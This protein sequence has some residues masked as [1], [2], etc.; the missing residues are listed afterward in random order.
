LSNKFAIKAIP[1]LIVQAYYEMLDDKGFKMAA[2]LSYYAVFSM[3]P[4]LIIIIAIAG[5]IFGDDAAKGQ[6]FNEMKS[7]L[8]PEGALMIETIVKGAA[9]TSTGIF[10]TAFSVV[11]LVLGSVGVFIE[12]QESLNIIWGVEPRPGRGIWG[13]LKLRLI[14]FSMV[15]ATAFLLMVSLV[16]NSAVTMLNTYMSEKFPV[17]IPMA[18]IL[19]NLGSL[20]VTILLFALIYKVLPDVNISIRY[21]WLGSILT[22]VLFTGGKFLI[23]AYLGSSSYASTYGAAASLVI[24]FVWIYYSGLILFFGAEITQVYRKRYSEKPL[25]PDRDGVIVP[26]VSEL[27]EKSLK[28]NIRKEKKNQVRE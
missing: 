9:D 20:I 4:L 2:A 28:N 24:L 12:L 13:F 22:S 11:L 14:S 18:F 15:V 16:I 6:V 10:A 27:I 23:G 1:G 21:V 26:K 19:N 7:L 3:G 25:T 5:F 8:G 17:L